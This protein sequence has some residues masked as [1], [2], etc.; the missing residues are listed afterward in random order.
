MEEYSLVGFSV[1]MGINATS[2][3]YVAYNSES[4]EKFDDLG[5]KQ[6]DKYGDPLDDHGVVSRDQLAL[7]QEKGY[8]YLY[9]K[10]TD[11]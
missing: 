4:A 10:V 8:I 11:R 2:G 3:H 6:H 1:H 7:A 5:G 9:K